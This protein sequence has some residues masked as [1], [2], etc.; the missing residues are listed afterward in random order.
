MLGGYGLYK[1]TP[2]TVVPQSP[3][4]YSDFSYSFYMIIAADDLPAPRPD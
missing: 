1:R 2:N 4:H 3:V